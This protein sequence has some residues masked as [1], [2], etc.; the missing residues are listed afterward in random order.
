[1]KETATGRMVRF[2]AATEL[3][4]HHPETSS[5]A[6]LISPNLHTF[7]GFR[8]IYSTNNIVTDFGGISLS[9]L[10]DNC[11]PLT[12]FFGGTGLLFFDEHLW[13]ETINKQRVEIPV[14]YSLSFDTQVAEAFRRYESNKTVEDWDWFCQLVKFVKEREFNFDYTFYIVEDLVHIFNLSNLRPFNTIRALK[15]FDHLDFDSF[16]RNPEAPIFGEDRESAGKRAAE[17]IYT[18]QND[19]FI[20][21]SLARRKGLKLV[22]L[23]AVQ[24]RWTSPQSFQ[25]NL[26]EL[27]EYSMKAL[28][29]FAKMEIYFAWKLLKYGDEFCFFNP[30]AKPTESA[31]K[32]INGMSWDLFSIRNQEL[33]ATFTKTGRFQVPFI[34]TFDRRFKQLIKACPVRCLLIDDT[35]GRINTIFTDELEF[36]IDVH[37]AIS[38]EAHSIIADPDEKL[39]RYSRQI[40][41]VEYDLFIER[42]FD[43]CHRI[44]S[45][46]DAHKKGRLINK[47]YFEPKQM[48]E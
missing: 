29:R 39:K 23:K 8:L 43:D 11:A 41:E 31:L 34:A 42:L 32:K 20:K 10:E 18:F 45:S 6:Q 2:E 24:L 38:Q 47:S 40:N 36:L 7:S 25:D 44:I 27:V 16:K 15:R 17:T 21:R 13:Q 48:S 1:M 46:G 4:I 19:D 9:D 37:E 26:S 3:I 5:L 33:L 12:R 35:E 28:G 14:G 22:L 30:V